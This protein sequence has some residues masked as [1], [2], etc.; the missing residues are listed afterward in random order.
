MNKLEKNNELMKANIAAMRKTQGDEHNRLIA[1]KWVVAAVEGALSADEKGNPVIATRKSFDVLLA[2]TEESIKPLRP[3]LEKGESYTKQQAAFAGNR[4][5][6]ER[7]KH[8]QWQKW[9]AKEYPGSA[10]SKTAQATNL[11]RKYGIPEGV[12]TIRK[13]LI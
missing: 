4:H 13:R 12:G 5:A 11:K 10:L 2:N 9:Q 8:A 6:E 3:L 1:D 7:G